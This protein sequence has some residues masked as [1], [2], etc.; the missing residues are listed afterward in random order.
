MHKIHDVGYVAKIHDEAERK[1]TKE[2]F[3][4]KLPIAK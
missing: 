3:C 4:S 2:M 1:I